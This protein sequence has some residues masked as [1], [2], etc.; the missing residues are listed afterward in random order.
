MLDRRCEASIPEFS[1]KR[2]CHVAHEN[3]S[4]SVSVPVFPSP[5]LSKPILLLAS[6]LSSEFPCK[7]W[8][9]TCLLGCSVLEAAQESTVRDK[10]VW[11][12]REAGGGDGSQLPCPSVPS[13]PPCPSLWTA[14]LQAF[15]PTCPKGMIFK[16]AFLLL[17]NQI[18]PHT[19]LV[20]SHTDGRCRQNWATKMQR[21]SENTSLRENWWRCWSWRPR[22]QRPCYL[23]PSTHPSPKARQ[24][25]P[26]SHLRDSLEILWRQPS[27]SPQE[28]LCPHRAA[29]HPCCYVR[30]YFLRVSVPHL[31]NEM[32]RR[33][34]TAT[35]SHAQ[36][37]QRS[38]SDPP[39]VCTLV[40]RKSDSKGLWAP[41]SL[42]NAARC[43]GT[44]ADA[45]NT[46]VVKSRLFFEECQTLTGCV[47]PTFP[48]WNS[49]SQCNDVCRCSLWEVIT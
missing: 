29:Y 26:I 32:A 5:P 40:I 34:R 41:L 39:E 36:E 24:H 2:M 30:V 14:R 15:R 4:S 38:L 7:F 1:A 22:K 44:G 9:S 45:V 19:C 17:W 23:H 18:N 3:G 6:E 16:I 42:H 11:G 20:K 33:Q 35:M 13:H 27:V 31:P 37:T 49:N 48:C 25:V 12:W 47:P 46:S 43:S 8:V 10:K 28:L 21:S